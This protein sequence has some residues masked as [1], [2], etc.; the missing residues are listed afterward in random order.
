M[1]LS[2]SEEDELEYPDETVPLLTPVKEWRAK[3]VRA[4]SVEEFRS[5]K[6]SKF[7]HKYNPKFKNRGPYLGPFKQL[8]LMKNLKGT[9]TRAMAFDPKK[10]KFQC[11]E[12]KAGDEDEG[13]A[14]PEEVEKL[15][16]EFCVAEIAEE[17]NRKSRSKS[18]N[19]INNNDF[20]V[21]TCSLF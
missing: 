19:Y 9:Y 10:Y 15:P 5:T 4:M 2:E 17:K 7:V 20:R 8:V 14:H 1:P 12:D 13:E 21:C 3:P 16:L 11:D 6:L 18:L